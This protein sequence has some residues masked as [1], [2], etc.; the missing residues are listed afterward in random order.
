[1]AFT[2]LDAFQQYD[3][4]YCIIT[5]GNMECL[6]LIGHTESDQTILRVADGGRLEFTRIR[7]LQLWRYN[8]HF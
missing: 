5:F 6:L 4:L 8:L 2:R 1:M 7:V 3:K